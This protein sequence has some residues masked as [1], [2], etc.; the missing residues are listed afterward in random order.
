[1]APS[2]PP[3]RQPSR[4]AP[5]Q[6]AVAQSRAKRPPAQPTTSAAQP[7]PATAQPRPVTPPPPPKSVAAGQSPPPRR[8]AGGAGGL[9]VVD[10]QFVA[11]V[12]KTGEVPS[13]P[14]EVAVVG[15]SNVGKSSLLNALCGRHQLARTSRTPGRTQR[16]VLFDARLSSG[17]TLRL[18]DLPGF[19]HA[20]VSKQQR[21]AF[22]EMIQFYLLGA[23]YLRLVL[24]LQDARRERDED[25]IGFALWLRE[26]GVA[27]DVVATK[28]D[29][30]PRNRI[31]AVQAR[32][33][34][35]FKLATLPL[36]VSAHEGREIGTLLLRL[37][38][39]AFPK[40]SK[41]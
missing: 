29:E 13:G 3:P 5:V 33:Q 37:R 23:E 22:G 31:H 19:G 25:A 20:E 10:A 26:N 9:R 21:A 40:P 34:A 27:Y 16:I 7:R 12:A 6:D 36:A 18:V 2:K 11:A 14:P 4:R 35:E 17:Q 8:P 28:A 30:V 24:I 38:N 1:V 32:L 39:A 15:R 41:G